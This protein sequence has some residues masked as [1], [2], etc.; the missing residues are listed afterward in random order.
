MCPGLVTNEL[1]QTF[2]LISLYEEGK[3]NKQ[4]GHMQQAFEHVRMLE[5]SYRKWISSFYLNE[6]HWTSGI[7]AT[8]LSP[9]P[10]I[11]L[12]LGMLTKYIDQNDQIDQ[13]NDRI[14]HLNI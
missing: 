7:N 8:I 1:L 14:D 4:Q 12:L 10:T 13:D 9:T 11:F 6:I 5:C 2:E 3:L